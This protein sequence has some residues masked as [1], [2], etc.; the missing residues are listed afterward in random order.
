MASEKF[1]KK[2]VVVGN[3]VWC[4][5][6]VVVFITLGGAKSWGWGRF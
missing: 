1:G 3:Y 2:E 5:V 4:L 6:I